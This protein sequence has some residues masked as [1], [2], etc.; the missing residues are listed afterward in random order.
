VERHKLAMLLE[1]KSS[2]ICSTNKNY[3]ADNW[4]SCAWEFRRGNCFSS[5]KLS[6]WIAF[7]IRFTSKTSKNKREIVVDRSLFEDLP[8][9]D[10]YDEKSKKTLWNYFETIS[11]SKK[12]F[13]QKRRETEKERGK[14]AYLKLIHLLRQCVSRNVMECCMFFYRQQII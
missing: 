5:W 3:V 2:W 13:I 6:N 1:N 11:S 12:S 4:E 9:L 7:T 10:D 8:A 14:D